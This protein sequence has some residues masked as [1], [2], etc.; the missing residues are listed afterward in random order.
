MTEA[1]A[2]NVSPSVRYRRRFDRGDW[3]WVG[4]AVAGAV[5]IAV[6]DPRTA[7]TIVTVLAVFA[8]AIERLAVGLGVLV[9]TVPIQD[10]WP[11]MV[12]GHPLTWTPAVLCGVA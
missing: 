4:V 12:A 7:L 11:A 5:V 10:A 1:I 9:A 6:V 8:L 3:A 2:S